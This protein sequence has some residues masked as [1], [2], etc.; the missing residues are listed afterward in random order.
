VTALHGTVAKSPE[1][2]TYGYGEVVE[3]TASAATGYH[4]TGWSGDTTAS[5]SPLYLPMTGNRAITAEFARDS[6]AITVVTG[7]GGTITPAGPSVMVANGADQ[8]FTITPSDGYMTQDVRVDDVPQGPLTTYTFNAVSSDHSIAAV[9]VPFGTVSI[10]PPPGYITLDADSVTVPVT[11]SRASPT[12]MLFAFS[13]Q[14]TVSPPL[15]LPSGRA[16]MSLGP[17]LEYDGGREVSFQTID[18]GID[19]DGNHVYQADGLTLGS[20]CGSSATSGTLF[21]IQLSSAA[22]S[23]S[24]TVT[25]SSVKLRDCGNV[26]ITPLLG[27]SATVSVDRSAPAVTLAAP[28][29]GETWRIGATETVSWTGSDPEGIADYDLAYSTDGGATYPHVIATVPAPQTSYAWTIPATVATAAKVRVTAHDAHG[30]AASDAS[31]AD[32][33]IDYCTITATAGA[34]GTISPSGT[35]TVAYDSSQTFAITPDEHYHVATLT[36]DGSPATPAASYTF[37]NVTTSHTIDVTFAI[38]ENVITATA[39]AHGTISP[40][41]AVSVAYDSSQTF[42]I[43]PDE[44]YHVA[45]LTVDGSPVTP[46]TSYTFSH[47]TTSHTIDATFAIDTYALGVTI[48]GNGTVAKSPDQPLYEHGT[49]VTL[50]A[51]PAS[52][53]HLGEWSGGA[54]GSTSPVTVVMDGPKTVTATFVVNPPV[55]AITALAATQVRSGNGPGSTTRIAVTW[56]ALSSG[57][58]VEVWR[59][60]FGN[61]PEYDDGASP[62]SVPPLPGSPGTYPPGS[63]WTVTSIHTSGE[64]DAPPARDYY[65]YVAYVTDIYGTRS[66][67]S[68]RAGGVL[69]YH[70]G[71]V[72]DGAHP[73]T[74]DEVVDGVDLSLLGIH[75]GL[76]GAGVL[77]YDYLDVGPTSTNWVDGLPLTDNQVDFE[78]LVMFALNYGLVSAPQTSARPVAAAVTG[79]DEVVLERPEKVSAGTPVTVRLTVRGSGTLRALST[80]LRWDPAVVEPLRQTAGDWLLA[81]DGVAFPAGPGKVDAAVLGAKGMTGEG[82]LA[83]LE[84]RVLA[85][86]DP[87]IGI[88]AVDAR[89]GGNHKVTVSQSERLVAP[90]VPTVTQL[91]RATPNPFRGTATIAFSLAQRG[92]VELAIFSVDGRRVRTLVSEVREPGEYRDVWDGRDDAGEAAAAG[93]Y[94]AHL[95]AAQRR[96]TRTVVYLK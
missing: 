84:F 55:A 54:S 53:W 23:G 22:L 60:A 62:G 35:V 68:N 15:E 27:S 50:T 45:T 2:A 9:F 16:S 28:N 87:K 21:T 95:T 67:I 71:D 17:F 90:K 79:S 12:P 85:A 59:A 61:Y 75:Y 82:V 30:N 89:D 56:P 42:A 80:R 24:G 69:D 93:V 39:G 31:D 96:F 74:G 3:L 7:S 51:S 78:D 1:Q 83:T 34:H 49:P 14:F 91:A 94:Y 4:F 63:R 33:T 46:A 26:S 73:G 81:Q 70:L 57:S 6:F 72:T 38:D 52:G 8:T 40:S 86:G 20:P 58:T 64:T 41:G 43:T 37:S 10:G 13:V 32:F 36:V 5:G 65:Y 25:L 77:A 29:G 19:G 48:V 44:H 92:P 66:P 47:V 88:E 18:R 76:S 11:I